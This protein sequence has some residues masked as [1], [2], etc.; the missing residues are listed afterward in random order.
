MPQ[1]WNAVAFLEWGGCGGEIGSTFSP[2][3]HRDE[4]PENVSL[5]FLNGT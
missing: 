1:R 5:E 4:L 2:Q 3:L